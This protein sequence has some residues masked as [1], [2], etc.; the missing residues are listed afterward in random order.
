MLTVSARET[1]ADFE[2]ALPPPTTYASWLNQ[3]ERWFG[4]ITHR[5]IRRVS[6]SRVKE[7]IA[8]IKQFVAAYNKTKAPSTA[9]PRQIQ[10]WRSSSDF[11]H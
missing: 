5:S 10:A 4:L 11:A 7:L 6:F 3:M 8:N 9:R 1:G 2:S